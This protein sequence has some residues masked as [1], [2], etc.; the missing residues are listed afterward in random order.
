MKTLVISDLH[1]GHRNGRDVLCHSE[2]AREALCEQVVAADRLV[3]LGDTLELR[4]GS[5]QAMIERSSDFLSE[6][7]TALGDG[8]LVLVAGNHDHRLISRW[9]EHRSEIGESLEV[10]S[11]FDPTETEAT[12][13]LAE[14]IGAERTT[15]AYPGV[16]LRD[17]IYATHGHYLD[18]QITV[19]SLERLAVG[20]MGGLLG[21]LPQRA[22]PDDYETA[23]APLYAWIDAIVRVTAGRGMALGAGGSVRLWRILSGDSAS[24][25]LPMRLL[26]AVS[27]PIGIGLLNRFGIGP[28]RPDISA[29]ELRR[30]GLAA[31]ATVVGSLGVD[32]PYV[33]FGHTH[34]TGPL[35]GD[36][37][38][39]WQLGNGGGR[40]LN[41][42]SWVYEPT[43]LDGAS[44][45]DPYWPGG[46]VLIEDDA[47][48]KLL[49]LL[50]AVTRD[51]LE[52]H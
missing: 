12:A 30:A 18:R 31:M 37:S 6:L 9:L 36:I 51:Q 19:P 7:G 8:K 28:L 20:A 22:T 21:R 29:A 46:A 26:G 47:P 50:D 27:L 5:Y 49:R 44:S 11:L 39:E 32:S 48:P 43:F 4:H 42:G 3:L 45:E 16:W 33:I 15:V 34:R 24:A 13:A 35:A 14:A 40:L 1:L 2:A 38:R 23:L 52:T 10:E 25:R 41:S 17:D